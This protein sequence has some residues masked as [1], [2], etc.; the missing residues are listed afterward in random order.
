[1]PDRK[2]ATS[3]EAPNGPLRAAFLLCRKKLK[4]S[5]I[6]EE[7]GTT[8]ATV[9][10]LLD[11]AE[12]QRFL[13]RPAPKLDCKRLPDGLLEQFEHESTLEVDLAKALVKIMSKPAQRP[14]IHVIAATTPQ[15]FIAGVAD[16]VTR[17]LARIRVIGVTGGRTT[18]FLLSYLQEHRDLLSFQKRNNLRFIPLSGDPT[19]VINLEKQVHS[20]SHLAA[21]F[22]RLILGKVRQD[23]PSLAG[24]PA[25][26]AFDE[27]RDQTDALRRFVR[28]IPG[29]RAIF[30]DAGS[31]V[32]GSTRQGLISDVQLLLTGVGAVGNP[33][34]K[35]AEMGEFILERICQHN[36]CADLGL[37]KAISSNE[38]AAWIHGDIAG[39]L[40]VKHGIPNA[41]LRTV[42][43]LNTGWTGVNAV[44]LQRV[45]QEA[46]RDPRRP[47]VVVI[48][49]ARSKATV[50]AET[51]RRGLTHHLVI[52][53]RLGRHLLDVI[54]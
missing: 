40:L 38:L 23:S 19:F 18:R 1:M 29:Y 24:V 11:Q 46:R 8:Q 53:A 28:C 36:A 44:H 37:G 33:N 3:R 21:D 47:G 16:Y 49:F 13:K 9:S 5:E 51:I 7:L 30:G 20:A 42:E 25:Y 34:N 32:N 50:I 48:A 12:A 31:G 45:T 26:C 6:A 10:R 22:E 4:Q 54:S 17:L 43:A 15:R 14:K 2:L 41:A 27:E 52:S 35:E 39:Y